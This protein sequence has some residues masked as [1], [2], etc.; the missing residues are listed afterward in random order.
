MRFVRKKRPTAEELI[1]K[2]YALIEILSYHVI[3]SQRII[4]TL[5]IMRQLLEGTTA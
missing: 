4:Y 2:S 3:L 1:N 5:Y